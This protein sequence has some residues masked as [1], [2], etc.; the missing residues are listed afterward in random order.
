MPFQPEVQIFA[1][2]ADRPEA[3]TKLITAAKAQNADYQNPLV[4]TSTSFGFATTQPIYD[5]SGLN[6]CPPPPPPS[7]ASAGENSDPTA[8]TAPSGKT[9]GGSG[10]GRRTAR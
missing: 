8:A 4:L 5:A 2:Q 7:E 3:A 10:A 1:W 6:P 9:A